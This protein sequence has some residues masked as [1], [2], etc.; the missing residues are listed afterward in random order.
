MKTEKIYTQHEENKEWHSKLLFYADEIKIMK[1]R[2][3][4]IVTKNTSKDILA[5]V[6]HFQNQLIIQ[7]NTIDTIKHGVNISEDALIKNISNNEV[8]VDHRE[9]K[10][11]TETREML[12]T[13]E[14][15][16]TDLKHEL[17]NSLIKWM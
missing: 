4:E 16:F 15:T 6:E 14:K 7:K 11:H 2:L 5:G 12:V 13:F 8:A 17:N 3:E 9:V 10:D 1:H